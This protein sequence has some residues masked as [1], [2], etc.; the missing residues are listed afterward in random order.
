MYEALNGALSTVAGILIYALPI[1]ILL[2]W[3][4]K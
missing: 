4:Y 1:S 2:T 3:I